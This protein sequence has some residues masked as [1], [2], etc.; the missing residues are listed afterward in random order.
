MLMKRSEDLAEF[1]HF[2]KGT[3]IKGVGRKAPVPVEN[4]ANIEEPSIIYIVIVI[5]T[6]ASSTFNML[7]R[8]SSN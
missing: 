5:S 6:L 3:P 8:T 7:Y 1:Q 2:Y 4:L